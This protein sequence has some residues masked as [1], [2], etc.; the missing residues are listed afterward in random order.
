MELKKIIGENIN[1]YLN[2]Q[3][4]LIDLKTELSNLQTFTKSALSIQKKII[5]LD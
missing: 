1:N 3:N 4:I 5:Y 2:S